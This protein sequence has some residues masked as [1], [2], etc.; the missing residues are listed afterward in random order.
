MSHL[1][2][3]QKGW[4]PLHYAARNGFLNVVSL[5][6]DSG[7]DPTATTKDGKVALCCAAAAGHIDV[8]SYLLN[9]EHDPLVLMDDK[10]VIIDE[11]IMSVI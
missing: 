10:T 6:I 7:A 3:F 9:Q 2:L 5:L 11:P 4:S 8:L 1:I